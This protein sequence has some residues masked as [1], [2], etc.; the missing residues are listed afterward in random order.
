M[1]G[2]HVTSGDPVI[3]CRDSNIT[4]TLTNNSVKL[5]YSFNNTINKTGVLH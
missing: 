4:L 1:D 2:V 5:Y 3:H